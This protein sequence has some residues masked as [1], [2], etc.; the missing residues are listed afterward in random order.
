M[1]AGSSKTARALIAL[2][3]ATLNVALVACDAPKPPQPKQA[4]APA[5]TP[6]P[7]DAAHPKE[8]TSTATPAPTPASPWADP[9]DKRPKQ[10]INLEVTAQHLTLSTPTHPALSL[11]L[12]PSLLISYRDATDLSPS[13]SQALSNPQTLRFPAP[14]LITKPDGSWSLITSIEHPAALFHLSIDA[15][16]SAPHLTQT[17]TISYHR[18]LLVEQEAL[19]FNTPSPEALARDYTWQRPTATKPIHAGQSTM[20]AARWPWITLLAP[21]AQGLISASN[22]V[23][24]E[25]DHRE[26]HPFKVY[27]SCPATQQLPS[28]YLDE[29]RRLRGQQE[30]YTIDW[31]IGAAPAQQL[32]TLR[33]FPNGHLSAISL[34]DHADQNQL[35]RTEALAFGQTGALATPDSPQS[36]ILGHGLKLTKTIFLTKAKGYNAQADLPAFAKLLDAMQQRGAQLG[37]HSI[38]G[39][40]DDPKAAAPLIKQ[41]QQRY[42]LQTWI[43]HEP[44]SN[45]EAIS[46]QGWDKTSPSYSLQLIEEAGIRT[47][48]AVQDLPFNG[49]NML[50]TTGSARRPVLYRHQRLVHDHT[51][52]PPLLFASAWFFGAKQTWTSRFSAKNLDRLDQEHGIFIGHTYLDVWRKDGKFA[53]RSL[54]DLTGP[55]QYTI[56]PEIDAIWADLAKRQAKHQTLTEGIDTVGQHLIQALQVSITPNPDGSLSITNPSDIPLRGLT[57]RLPPQSQAVTLDGAPLKDRLRR[58]EGLDVWFDLNAKATRTLKLTAASDAPMSAFAPINLNIR[59]DDALSTP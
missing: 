40:L 27:A 30:S 51:H 56:K 22:Y 58:P 15:T 35:A 1:P 38:S 2:T 25:L 57:L 28:R 12:S 55:E 49:L 6:T 52:L 50:S 59:I 42:T 37:L 34:T 11:D 33:R 54:L 7:S 29:T 31:L 43:D 46:N 4:Q 21:Q 9:E 41:A 10:A 8:T 24:V 53:P 39:A 16:G 3:S 18:D 13:D 14:S 23:E 45:C 36:G 32:P 44:I 26:L 48:W 47:L 17:L 5:Q 19:R 20:R